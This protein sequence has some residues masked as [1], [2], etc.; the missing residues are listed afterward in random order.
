MEALRPRWEAAARQYGW[1][2]ELLQRATCR[3]EAAPT[4]RAVEYSSSGD[5]EGV[6][7]EPPGPPSPA[8]PPYALCNPA[9]PVTTVERRRPAMVILDSPDSPM[10]QQQPAATP[11]AA[12]SDDDSD[13]PLSTL[14]RR[15]PP[16]V[17]RVEPAGSAAAPVRR[18]LCVYSDDSD[19]DVSLMDTA[20]AVRAPVSAS[21]RASIGGVARRLSAGIRRFIDD[22]AKE[23][24]GDSSEESSEAG[25]DS[26]RG[27]SCGSSSDNDD[28]GGSGGDRLLDSHGYDL[29]DGFIASDGTDDD[30]E[31]EDG[32]EDSSDG[33]SSDTEVRW[34]PRGPTTTGASKPREPP[35]TPAAAAAAAPPR[36]VPAVDGLV[37]PRT[38]R[39]IIA[40]EEAGAAGGTYRFK[41]RAAKEALTAALYSEYNAVVFHGALPP[42]MALTWNARLLKT[43]GLTYS[44]RRAVA[45]DV[46]YTSRI[47]LSV[48][49]LDTPLKLAQVCRFGH[50]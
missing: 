23:A 30:E 45:G 8:S 26:E 10:Q 28:D 35:Q 14:R 11:A 22:A 27:D 33:A 29:E 20:R 4:A 6:E 12:S 18:T 7:N 21:A 9:P 49:V 47:E 32:E 3:Y 50:Q 24:R 42:D 2:E 40:E 17:P 43:A 19:Q 44:S 31:E 38:G 1:S 46:V 39:I 16:T 48:K 5:D 37:H 13:V 25:S 41:N 36:P 15:A 34:R